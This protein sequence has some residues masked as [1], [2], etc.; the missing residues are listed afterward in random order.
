MRY[1]VCG[2]SIVNE[3][4]CADGTRRGPILGGSVYCLAGLRLWTSSCGYVSNVGDDFESLYGSWFAAN[5]ISTDKVSHILPHTWHTEL[6]YGDEGIHDERSVFGE[7]DEEELD[8]L[9]V[10]RAEQVAA[11]CDPD[12]A[13]IYVESREGSEFWRGV[14]AVREATNA[15]IMWEPPTSAMMDPARRAGVIETIGLTDAYSI[16]LPEA[17][18]L[19]DVEGEREAIDAIIELGTP[20]FLR[21]GARG[22]HMV[23]DGRSAFAPSVTVG[24]V[25]DPTGCGNAST[26]A[27]LYGLV[28]GLDPDRTARLANVSAA[29]NLLQWGPYPRVTESDEACARELLE[30]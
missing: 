21:A 6:V 10:I 9:D 14:S 19:F 13:G 8:R 5:G 28:E 18:A 22:S 15:K 26:A 29:F 30:G 16:N 12:T 7:A 27:A 25:M 17:R 23:Q 3:V 4:V 20:C 24:E 2:P 1:I 11:A